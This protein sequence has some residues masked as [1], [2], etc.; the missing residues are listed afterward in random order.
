MAKTEKQSK[1]SK[2][3]DIIFDVLKENASKHMTADEVYRLV[4][5]RDK[6]IGVATVYRNLKFLEE[7]GSI[8]R[9]C[10]SENLTSCYELQNN[11]DIHSHHHLVCRDC[12]AVSDFEEDLLDAIE[13]I[14]KVTTGFEIEDHHLVFYGKC[15]K[16]KEERKNG[17]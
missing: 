2:K 17:E 12:G 16:C 3:R 6:A 4:C 15:N 8:K 5:E 1:S 14:I 10:I 13:K 11:S 7:K 9:A